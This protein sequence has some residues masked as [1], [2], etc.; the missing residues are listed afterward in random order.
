MLVV[1]LLL[2]PRVIFAPLA[3]RGFFCLLR[4]GDDRWLVQYVGW[5]RSPRHDAFGRFATAVAG[6]FP[7][8]RFR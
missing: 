2:S 5:R 1:L 8:T 7:H 3:Q 6:H 4:A